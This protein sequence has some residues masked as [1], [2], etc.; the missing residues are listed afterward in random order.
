MT[1]RGSGVAVCAV[2]LLLWVEAASAADLSRYREFQLGSSVAAV[3][4]ATGTAPSDVKVVHQRPAVIQ[5][6]T[7]RPKSAARPS[8]ADP[9]T[10]DGILFRFYDGQLFQVS[11]DYDRER[12]RGLSEP[13]MIAAIAEVYGPAVTPSSAKRTPQGPTALEQG[14]GTPLAR[15]DDAEHSILLY[16]SSYGFGAGFTLVVSDERLAALARTA[17]AQAL[18]LDVREAPQ[19]AAAR[20]KQNEEDRRAAEEKARTANKPAF[21]P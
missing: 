13:D 4:T 8:S 14:R 16:R 1:N 19:R 21:R 17:T 6:L 2:G 5:E 18:A 15:W 3:S 10:A 12:T 11:V 7:W 20:A 9:E